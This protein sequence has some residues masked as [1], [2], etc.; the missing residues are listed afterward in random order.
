MIRRGKAYDDNEILNTLH[1]LVRE[2]FLSKYRSFTPPQKYAIVE[3]FKGNNV[4]I[5][6]PTGSGK[7]LA[8]FLAAISML[9]EKAEKNELGDV[10]HVVYVSPLR[11]LNND[12]KRNLEE[13]LKEI[14]ELAEK[15]GVKLQKIRIAVRTGDT[16]ASERQKQMR[17]PPHILITTPETLAI[18]LCSPKF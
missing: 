12:I 11:A 10:T 14:Y 4:L 1:P 13:P 17:K 16:D 2:W 5:T 18:L 7:T 15:K 3:A 6:S 8:A 9:V